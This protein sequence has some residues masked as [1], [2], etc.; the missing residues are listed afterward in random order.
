MFLIF[1]ALPNQE[2]SLL[3]SIVRHNNDDKID[4]TAIFPYLNVEILQWY[5]K[6]L[7]FKIAR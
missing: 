7:I 1:F 2:D 3:I 4:I 5:V 6:Y